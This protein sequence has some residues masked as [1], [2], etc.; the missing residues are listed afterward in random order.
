MAKALIIQKP[1]GGKADGHLIHTLGFLWSKK[2][3]KKTKQK[4]PKEPQ[5]PPQERSIY[6]QKKDHQSTKLIQEIFFCCMKG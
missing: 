2:T 5:N 4:T 6:I 1:E 3:Q